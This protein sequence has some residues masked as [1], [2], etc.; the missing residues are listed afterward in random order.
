MDYLT[1]FDDH[2]VDCLAAVDTS[3][4][5]TW[6]LVQLKITNYGLR[7]C[8]CP[9]H[10]FNG[11]GYR[12]VTGI[13]GIH[14][15]CNCISGMIIRQFASGQQVEKVRNI[16]G[17][18]VFDTVQRQFGFDHFLHILLRMKTDDWCQ[19]LIRI[20]QQFRRTTEPAIA[21]SRDSDTS[22]CPVQHLPCLHYLMD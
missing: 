12:I 8:K 21:V 5:S 9:L 15:Q 2:I 20:S 16:M 19:L 7:D 4:R 1:A 14:G 3:Y 10:L 22:N 6:K 13:N 17:T 11:R 18:P